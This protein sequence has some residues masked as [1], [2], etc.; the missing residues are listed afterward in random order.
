MAKSISKTSS[1]E[2]SDVIERRAINPARCLGSLYDGVRDQVIDQSGLSNHQ[3]Q[4]LPSSKPTQCE[5]INNIAASNFN[6][7]RCV[8]IEPELRLSLLLKL[9]KRSGIAEILDY[10]HPIDQYTCFFYYSWIKHEQTL[11]KLLGVQEI[12]K[13]WSSRVTATHVITGIRFGI[14]LVMILQLPSQADIYDK[15]HSILRKIRDI[16]LNEKK[17]RVV[18]TP[19]E[20]NLLENFLK[21][22]VYSNASMLTGVTKISDLLSHIELIKN[23]SKLCCPVTY[24]LQT[25]ASLCHAHERKAPEFTTLSFTLINDL[26]HY[27]LQ[28]RS[29]MKYLEASLK[30]NQTKSLCK[31][32]QQLFNETSTQF[33]KVKDIYMHEM[34]RFATLVVD[35]R[36][37][38]AKIFKINQ[39]LHNG[40]LEKLKESIHQLIENLENLTTQGL[41]NTNLQQKH[42]ASFTT[43]ERHSSTSDNIITDKYSLI[44]SDSHNR[45][46]GSND[47][48][49]EKSKLS[50]TN[51]HKKTTIKDNSSSALPPAHTN[52]HHSSLPQWYVTMSTSDKI[53]HSENHFKQRLSSQVS[54]P[55]ISSTSPLSS[56]PPVPN[57]D[58][59]N[60]LLLGETGVG[61]STFINAFAN[62]LI[63]NSF[64]Q[65]ES[66]EPIVI[67]PVSFTQNGIGNIR[68][69]LCHASAKLAHFLIYTACS[70][71]DD[72]FLNGLAEMIVE[73]TYICEIQKT[74][75]FNIQLV[76]E[77]SKLES[78]YEQH[79]NKL[80]STKE[81]FDVQAVYELIK[82]ISN[83]PTVREQMITVKQRQRMIIEEYEYEV[84]NI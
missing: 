19:K 15:I 5:V 10:S 2:P 68:N 21:L 17:Y 32:H 70:T 78:Q 51:L 56:S 74:N 65:A 84:Q 43:T 30:E 25:I 48:L 79:M 26:E 22:K 4:W 27:M 63:F 54:A 39:A 52:A 33:L 59:I 18:L 62:Y 55:E 47:P 13:Q 61:K 7:L 73:E 75:D 45:N 1:K 38:P 24:I 31:H 72:P 20:N 49:K 53:D 44:N 34:H 37:R 80:K 77:L 82:I 16:L 42:F 12:S 3:E 23:H 40:E 76:Q 66:S 8:D 50:L 11:R 6:I 29:R 14:D 35:A 36:N 67:I 58:T 41:V 64:E 60:I 81:N 83:Y 71:K 69:T 57:D 46:L 28:C 9:A